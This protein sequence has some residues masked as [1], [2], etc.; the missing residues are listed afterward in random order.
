[1]NTEFRETIH[2]VMVELFQERLTIIEK[3]NGE[4]Y[5]EMEV[6]KKCLEEMDKVIRSI[7]EYLKYF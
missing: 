6:D 1:M 5:P 2:K 7:L 4:D 3:L